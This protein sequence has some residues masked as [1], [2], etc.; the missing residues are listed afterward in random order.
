MLP[1]ALIAE[2]FIIFDNEEKTMNR[3]TNRFFRPKYFTIFVIAQFFLTQSIFSSMDESPFPKT[4]L[5][6]YYDILGINEQ[7]ATP[8]QIKSVYEAL[9]K[10]YNPDDEDQQD[11]DD[12]KLEFN[13]YE[14]QQKIENLQEAYRE[15]LKIA[16]LH[17]KFYDKIKALSI[18]KFI[19][20]PTGS[21][22]L[23]AYNNR[24][25]NADIADIENDQTDEIDKNITSETSSSDDIN[26]ID[27]NPQYSFPTTAKKISQNLE[28]DQSISDDELNN[29]QESLD[30]EID[31]KIPTMQVAAK[32]LMAAA[33]IHAYKHHKAIQSKKIED[34]SKN[35]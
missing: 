34:E 9:M 13:K 10:Q 22:I 18:G 5:S 29:T 11:N 23:D 19:T 12:T 17:A 14:I 4:N 33:M 3:P 7:Q 2:F 30:K 16:L 28:D 15:T 21:T 26:T 6:I 32:E 25:S 8:K 27:E 20:M 1:P 24:T 35:R 31:E